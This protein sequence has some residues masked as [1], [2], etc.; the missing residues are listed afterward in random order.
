MYLTDRIFS[1]HSLQVWLKS[2]L[3]IK[4]LYLLRKLSRTDQE[5]PEDTSCFMM[6]FT[7][8]AS[9]I[10]QR[11]PLKLIRQTTKGGEGNGIQQ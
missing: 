1:S 11:V 4:C 3:Q 2:V 10:T 6:N 7:G 8:D 5:F 9:L